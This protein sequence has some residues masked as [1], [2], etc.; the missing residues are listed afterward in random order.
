VPVAGGVPPCGTAGLATKG[1]GGRQSH[2]TETQIAQLTATLDYGPG[3]HGHTEDQR[4]TLARISDVIQAMFGVRYKDSSTVSRLIRSAG[5]AIPTAFNG[6][7]LATMEAAYLDGSA[8]G[9]PNWTTYQQFNVALTPD[10]TAD[11]I[12]LPAAFFDGVADGSTV[13]LNFHFWSDALVTYTPT[14]SG[15]AVTGTAS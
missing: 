1:H 10:Y 3:A 7:K 14:R 15:T 12:T 11:L 2:L 13:D 6:D 8:A 5:Y 9:L 4:W